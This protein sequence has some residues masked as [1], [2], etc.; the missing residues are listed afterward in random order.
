[1][2][3]ED[4]NKE[5]VFKV[6][7]NRAETQFTLQKQMIHLQQEYDNTKSLVA[8]LQQNNADLSQKV[9]AM[10]ME[11]NTYKG[12]DENMFENAYR[13]IDENLDYCKKTCDKVKQDVDILK[14]K[15]Y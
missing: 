2:W 8:A 3:D 5:L 4:L 6:M 13:K 11:L 9:S 12:Y 7:I 10:R 15:D 14:A 1:M